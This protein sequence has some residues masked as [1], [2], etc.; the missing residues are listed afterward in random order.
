MWQESGSF[1]VRRLPT[2]VLFETCGW[3]STRIDPSD[4]S[5]RTRTWPSSRGSLHSI[6][7][8]SRT[9]SVRAHRSLATRIDREDR[10]SGEGFPSRING[11]SSKYYRSW[12]EE[13]A[14]NVGQTPSSSWLGRLLRKW[15]QSMVAAIDSSSRRNQ[16]H[17]RDHQYRHESFVFCRSFDPNHAQAHARTFSKRE[18]PH[19]SHRLYLRSSRKQLGPVLRPGFPMSK[20]CF[21]FPRDDLHLMRTRKQAKSLHKRW[22]KVDLVPLE[23]AISW[24]VLDRFY[25]HQ[26]RRSSRLFGGSRE[27]CRWWQ[28]SDN[29]RLD[30]STWS[31]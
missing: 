25:Q 16:V 4:G 10:T 14:T 17:V 7:E 9:S 20:L 28:R 5:D 30:T 24:C 12:K 29:D 2:V 3:A 26:Q 27:W 1:L 8:A 19:Q 31:Q 18:W 21:R 11:D 22:A 23:Q 15:S 6:R 13:F